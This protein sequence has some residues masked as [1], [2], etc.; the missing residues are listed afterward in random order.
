LA[1][2]QLHGYVRLVFF[3][4]VDDALTSAMALKG[5]VTKTVYDYSGLEKDMRVQAEFGGA[6]YAAEIV[7]ISRAK[8][9]SKAPVKVHFCG[10]SQDDDEWV[11]GS[12]L[13]SKALRKEVANEK[14]PKDE[15]PKEN[16]AKKSATRKA[17]RTVIKGPVAFLNKATVVQG[18][19]VFASGQ[20]GMAPG[21]D[22]KVALVEG[23]IQAEADQALKNMA[24]VLEEAGTDL[25]R[26]LKVNIFLT[27][28]ADFAAFNEVYVKHFDD[29]DNCPARTCLAAAALPVPGAKVEIECIAAGGK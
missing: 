11:D 14:G 15:V 25:K 28:I 16:D 20:L 12:R 13:R 24:A 29:P 26:C 17:Q 19:V 18:S 2:T 7:S 22:G 5:N 27:D 9:R 8:A 10:Y 1:Q 23:G 6:Y 4:F 21:P 3:G